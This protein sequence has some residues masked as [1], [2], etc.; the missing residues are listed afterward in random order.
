MSSTRYAVPLP[1]P[2]APVPEHFGTVLANL[3]GPRNIRPLLEARRAYVKAH[4]R[5][6]LPPPPGQEQLLVD[7]Q[8]MEMY[9]VLSQT[10]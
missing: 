4:P 1:P 7:R 9:T 5:P 2:P 10:R 3:V 6:E 8:L